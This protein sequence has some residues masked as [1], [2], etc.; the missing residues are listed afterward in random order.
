[1]NWGWFAVVSDLD[2]TREYLI[3]NQCYTDFE[4]EMG[5]LI[6]FLNDLSIH[7]SNV[8]RI[9]ITSSNRTYIFQTLLIDSAVKTL[10][11]VKQC[12]SF[13]GFSDANILT[14][15]YRD[16]LMLHLYILEVLN[17]RKVLTD[18]QQKDMEENFDCDKFVKF[19]ELGLYNTINGITKNSHDFIVD[20]WFED[21]ITNEQ[22][23]SIKRYMKYFKENES[24]AKMLNEYKLENEWNAIRT[25]LNDYT[26]NNG[27]AHTRDNVLPDNDLKTIN[28]R[29]IEIL[30]SLK[31][32]TSVFLMLLILIDPLMIQSSEYIDYREC[33]L[34]PPEDCQYNVAPFILDFLNEYVN[35]INP[36]LKA[37]LRHNNK[38]G[39]LIE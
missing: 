4:I 13:A 24:I 37:F 16:D 31:Y 9:C 28:T 36:E 29:L 3:H 1:M 33:E 17:N 6:D 20:A 11:S 32:I 15:K 35:T 5:K 39:M 19:V 7:V 8:G 14:R 12:C 2:R 21:K 25:K 18:A 23:L 27:Q 38:Y 26:H 22:Q 34:E 10:N 30:T